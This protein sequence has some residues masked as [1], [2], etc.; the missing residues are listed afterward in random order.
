MQPKLRVVAVASTFAV[1]LACGPKEEASPP[2]AEAPKVAKVEKPERVA[3]PVACENL[4]APPPSSQFPLGFDYP[5]PAAKIQSWVT[6][7]Q[8][9]RMRFHAYC[10]FAGLNQPANAAKDPTWRTWGCMGQV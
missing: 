1:F 4:G 7:G 3:D 10:V 2:V 9:P 8:G 5:Q 6:P